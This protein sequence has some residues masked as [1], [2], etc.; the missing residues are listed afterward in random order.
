MHSG[1]VMWFDTAACWKGKW[2]GDTT[3]LSI[4]SDQSVNQ[5]LTTD[6]TKTYPRG[7]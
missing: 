4:K 5:Q 3:S 2:I 1:M 6:P 7:T